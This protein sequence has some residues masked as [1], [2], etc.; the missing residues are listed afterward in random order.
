MVLEF[1][2]RKNLQMFKLNILKI[3][4]TDEEHGG[5][6]RQ[7]PGAGRHE[8]QHQHPVPVAGAGAGP[9]LCD[10]V[11][12]GEIHR[13]VQHAAGQRAQDGG[14]AGTTGGEGEGLLY[15]LFIYSGF[16]QDICWFQTLYMFMQNKKRN[17]NFAYN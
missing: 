14:A 8:A 7:Q 5:L 2:F 10:R 4:I 12:R 17:I 1:F 13:G 6:I 16:S 3:F 11:W 9:D 15:I